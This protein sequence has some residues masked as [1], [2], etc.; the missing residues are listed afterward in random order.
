MTLKSSNDS[1]DRINFD[2]D[3]HEKAWEEFT[4]LTEQ[5][6]KNLKDR[7]RIIK[8]IKLQTSQFFI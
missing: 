4:T 8:Q 3:Y 5:E 1:L 7:A 6:R 2:S